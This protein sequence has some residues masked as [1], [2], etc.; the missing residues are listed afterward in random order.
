M[1][2]VVEG[3]V[4]DAFVE[5]GRTSRARDQALGPEEHHHQ[6]DDPEDPELELGDFERKL[7]RVQGEEQDR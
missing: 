1:N 3:L 7:N 4:V 6:Q 5:L 2:H